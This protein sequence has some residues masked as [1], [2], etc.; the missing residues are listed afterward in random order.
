LRRFGVLI[1]GALAAAVCARLGVW[2]VS[3]LHQR[4]AVRAMVEARGHRPEF[5][6]TGFAAFRMVTLGAADSMAYRRP[7]RVVSSTSRARWWW[8][9]VRW[10]TSPPCIW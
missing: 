3:R 9:R 10:T 7:W 5:E 1:A 6:A 4:Q 8:W 2:Q